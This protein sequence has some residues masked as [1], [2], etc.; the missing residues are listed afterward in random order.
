MGPGIRH[1]HL[2]FERIK[3]NLLF[4]SHSQ[5]QSHLSSGLYVLRRGIPWPRSPVRVMINNRLL[6]GSY[7]D[8]TKVRLSQYNLPG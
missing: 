5:I 6:P 2:T 8:E 1:E 7:T 3:S 4:V